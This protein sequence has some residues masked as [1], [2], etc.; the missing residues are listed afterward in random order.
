MKQNARYNR[1][2][3]FLDNT[4]GPLTRGMTPRSLNRPKPL[5]CKPLDSMEPSEKG[6]TWFL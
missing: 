4:N 2:I 5:N 1:Y 6:D 3:L